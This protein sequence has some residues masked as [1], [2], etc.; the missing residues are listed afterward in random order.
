MKFASKLFLSA[1]MTGALLAG[2]A[3]ART[4]RLGHATSDTNPRHLAAQLFAKKVEE[5]SGGSLKITVAGNAQFG[6]DVEMMTALRLGTLDM[7]LNSQGS[8]AGV[9]PE[10]ATVGLPFLFSDTRTAWKV[11]DGPVGDDLAKLAASKGLVM[12]A[13]LDNGIRVTTNNLRPITKPEDLKGIKLRVPPDPMGTDTFAALGANPTP[14]KFS[15]L[16]LALQQG[17]VDGQENPVVNI[18]HSKFHEVQKYLSLTRHKYEMTP[19]LVSA[20]TWKTLS[21]KEQDILRKA[22]I[23][24]RDYQRELA[25][26]EEVELL[27]KI[28]A[29]GVQVNEVDAA[30]F[31]AATQSVYD[32]W[33]GQYGEF[34]GKLTAAAEAGR[35]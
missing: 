11:L 31:R 10:A 13:Y 16:Y 6:D 21:P 24:A 9:V 32:K 1:V 8:L 33:R 14:M 25:A 22:A 26:K 35:S 5:A 30:P 23:E 7:S 28:K 4:L 34:I 20:I 2:T 19:F 17:V 15:E 18:Y 12:L 27:D 29:A 3:E